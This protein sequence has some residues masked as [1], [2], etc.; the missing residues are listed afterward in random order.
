MSI[1]QL[2][3]LHF[4]KPQAN[5]EIRG[6]RDSERHV[7]TRLQ[8]RFAWHS[9][10]RAQGRF[11]SEQ[12]HELL[13]DVHRYKQLRPDF[14]PDGVTSFASLQSFVLAL[15][16]SL[17]IDRPNLKSQLIREHGCYCSRCR[18]TTYMDKLNPELKAAADRYAIDPASFE[19]VCDR[20]KANQLRGDLPIR[21]IPPSLS[22]ALTGPAANSS[23]RSNQ[24]ADLCL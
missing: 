8:H 15:P 3:A 5:V 6:H 21:R 10:R 13:N 2:E 17:A 4:A 22:S 20:C 14:Y 16:K 12:F 11:D 19:L 18:R 1:A 7:R 9:V 24:G 23:S